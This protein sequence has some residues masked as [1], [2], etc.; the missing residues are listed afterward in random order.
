MPASQFVCPA[1]YNE[2]GN[3]T[4]DCTKEANMNTYGYIRVS[5]ADQNEDRQR[6]ALREAGVSDTNIYMD[7]QSGK[8]F[9]RPGYTKEHL[10]S[11]SIQ[12]LIM[13][14]AEH[15]STCYCI[16]DSFVLNGD[17]HHN[18]KAFIWDIHNFSNK[19]C[20]APAKAKQAL[21]YFTL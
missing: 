10:C 15:S 11:R 1:W 2:G 16:D 9:D 3:I 4:A 17:M 8:D 14:V 19:P 5:S 20:F 7:K 13:H 21:H 6:I 12:L 18:G